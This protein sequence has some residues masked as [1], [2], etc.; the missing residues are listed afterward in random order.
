MALSP[1]KDPEIPHLHIDPMI[2]YLGQKEQSWNLTQVENRLAHLEHDIY[3]GGLIRRV[4]LAEERE[5]LQAIVEA[6]LLVASDK[7]KDRLWAYFMVLATAVT[8][9]LGGMLW[10]ISQLAT[11]LPLSK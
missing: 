1:D 7:A 5:R 3:N 11:S 9:A 4:D 2:L 8:L 6:R 10:K